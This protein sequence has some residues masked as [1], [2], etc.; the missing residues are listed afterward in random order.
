MN[1]EDYLSDWLALRASALA[2]RTLESY[3][4]LIK[5]YIVP[6]LGAVD[7]ADLTPAKIQRLL[8]AICSDGHQRTAQL[9][10]VLLRSALREAVD[11]GL[12]AANPSDKTLMPRHQRAPARWWTPDELRAFLRAASGTRWIIAWQLSLCCGLRRGELAGLRWED[13]DLAAGCLRIRNQRQRIKGVGV[14]DCA[15]K[16]AASRR[17]I[18]IPDGLRPLL[19]ATMAAQRSVAASGGVLPR[20]VVSY[21]DNRPIDPHQLNAALSEAI[22]T[23]GV[24]PIN[25][26]GLRHSMAS[27]AVSCGV[28]IKVLQTILGHAHY[29]TTADIY[30]HVLAADQRAAIDEVAQNVL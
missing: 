25:L 4:E 3:S 26:H 8:A 9:V 23:A 10:R 12:L 30:S 5:R 19:A 24:R 18:P 29:S 2:A 22:K 13:V 1:V 6:E 7:L 28:S 21:M 27:C 14:I 17:D 16:S 20:Y 15:P 11:C